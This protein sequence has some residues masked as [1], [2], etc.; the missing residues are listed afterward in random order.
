MNPRDSMPTMRVGFSFSNSRSKAP[1][2]RAIAAGSPRIGVMSLKI[3]PGFGKS[4]MS[5]IKRLIE[6]MAP[7]V[8]GVF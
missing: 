2:M 6:S 7:P 8:R 4:G 3:I 5:R 1:V